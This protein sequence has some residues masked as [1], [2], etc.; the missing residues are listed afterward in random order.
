MFVSV[1]SLFV[2]AVFYIT[3]SITVV[4]CLAWFLLVVDKPEQSKLMTQ[5]ERD[6]ILEHRNYDDSVENQ[7]DVPIIPLLM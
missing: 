4:W 5:E 7:D 3:A 2:Q 6:Y 1:M